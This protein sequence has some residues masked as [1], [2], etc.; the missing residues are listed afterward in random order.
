VVP[1]R[2]AGALRLTLVGLAAGLVAL[3][4]ALLVL[5]A[6]TSWPPHVVTGDS[7]APNLERGDLVF[8]E[9]IRGGTGDRV[10]DRIVTVVEGQ[11]RGYSRFGRHGDVIVFRPNASWNRGPL[12]HRAVRWI[13]PG[14]EWQGGNTTYTADHGGFLTDADGHPV[15][16]QRYRA[17]DVVRPAWVSGVARYRVPWLGRIGLWLAGL[18]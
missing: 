1:G 9:P 8:V 6:A 11:R 14:E 3:A 2:R 16:D 5:G 4:G 12:L 17:R 7:M 18:A 15:Y 13:E 10:R